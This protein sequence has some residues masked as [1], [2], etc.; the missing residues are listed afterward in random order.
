MGQFVTQVVCVQIMLS[1]CFRGKMIRLASRLWLGSLLWLLCRY[2]RFFLYI[3]E[4]EYDAGF[5]A[6]PLNSSFVPTEDGQFIYKHDAYQLMST[7]NE[8]IKQGLAKE[9][10]L[11]ILV[12]PQQFK[13]ERFCLSGTDFE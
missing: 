8:H 10:T 3:F 2:L 12:V 4:G 6:L 13:C 1:S 7:A 5:T 9:E 11:F